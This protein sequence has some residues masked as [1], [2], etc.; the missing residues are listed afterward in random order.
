MNSINMTGGPP[1]FVLRSSIATSLTSPGPAAAAFSIAASYFKLVS[2]RILAF[3]I[4]LIGFSVTTLT[5]AGDGL[6]YD[7]KKIIHLDIAARNIFLDAFK[8]PMI[9]D[10]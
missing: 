3:F 4:G 2:H 6:S 10:L 5:L 8:R 9:G 1:L 7:L